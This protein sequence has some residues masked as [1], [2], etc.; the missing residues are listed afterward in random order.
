MPAYSSHIL[1][2][3]DVSCFS[4]LKRAYGQ[5]IEDIM[6]AHISHITKD[7]FFPAFHATFNTVMTKS[8]I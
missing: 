4:P 3:L 7:D 5:Q 1:Q 6:Q 2:L 8:N